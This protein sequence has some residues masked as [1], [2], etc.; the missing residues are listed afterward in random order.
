VAPGG[1]LIICG[2]GSPRSGLAA[3]PVR[4]ILRSYG[5]EPEGEFAA[6]APEGGGP[7]IEI[8]VLRSA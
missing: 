8:A 6:E 4:R 5:F 7:I 3:H 1:R 2:C